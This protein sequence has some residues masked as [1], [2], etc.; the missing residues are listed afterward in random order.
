MSAHNDIETLRRRIDHL[1]R[2]AARLRAQLADLHGIAWEP[3]VHTTEPTRN[4][5]FESRPPP[6]AHR[7]HPDIGSRPPG[8]I[9]RRDQAHHLWDRTSQ[10]IRRCEELLVGLER[11]VTGWFMVTAAVEPTRGSLIRADDHDALLAARNRR[12]SRGEYTPSPVVDQ[13]AHPGKNR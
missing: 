6:G 1:T 12:Q 13:P 7:D 5:T 9:S 11:T 10:E 3:A 4:G 2:A 8:R